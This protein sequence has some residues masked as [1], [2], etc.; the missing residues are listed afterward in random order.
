MK[1]GRMVEKI[2]RAKAR[3]AQSFLSALCA[4]AGNFQQV[5]HFPI[6]IPFTISVVPKFEDFVKYEKRLLCE[7]RSFLKDTDNE[8]RKKIFL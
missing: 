2:F 4:F 5:V 6:T 1:R 8:F 3:R 7:F